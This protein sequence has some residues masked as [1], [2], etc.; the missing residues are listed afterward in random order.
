MGVKDF[1]VSTQGQTL[2]DTDKQLSRILD[3]HRVNAG[4]ERMYS[5]E[6]LNEKSRMASTKRSV[7]LT[8]EDKSRNVFYN[9]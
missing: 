3:D 7:H 5:R 1:L 8:H 4:F 6:I 9:N 2:K